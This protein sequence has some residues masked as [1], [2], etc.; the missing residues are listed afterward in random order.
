LEF[1]I[2]ILF[3]GG[4]CVGRRGHLCHDITDGDRRQHT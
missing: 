4:G 3:E 1:F 2:F